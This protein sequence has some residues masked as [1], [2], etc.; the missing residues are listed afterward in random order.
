M[1][2]TLLGTGTSQGI[3]VI[4]CN[5]EACL[6]EDRRDDRLRSGVLVQ[7][8][9][10]NILIDTGPDLRQQLLGVPIRHLNA[11]LYTHE[12]NDHVAGLDD[13]RP[14]NFIQRID[15][16]FYGLQRVLDNIE[17]RFSY[18]FEKNPYPGAPRASLHAIHSGESFQVENLN[19]T[20]IEVMHGTLPILGY[21]FG[22][23]AFI[24]DAS[25]ISEENKELLKGTKVM[26]LSALQREDHHSHFT[27]QEAIDLIQELKIEKGYLTHIS[28]RMGKTIEWEKDLPENIFPSFD[29]LELVI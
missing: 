27:L 23:F 25:L 1:K 17:R 13:I 15:M 10:V 7:S 8:D 20:P 22:D 14:F 4:G 21:R 2:I 24:T 12:H 6:S 5:C 9:G 3:P 18:V 16:P 28:H 26:V 19:I 29:G 11:V